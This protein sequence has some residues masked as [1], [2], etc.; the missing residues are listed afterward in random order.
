MFTCPERK[1]NQSPSLTAPLA[2]GLGRAA[3]AGAGAGPGAAG[4]TAPSC[5]PG[6]GLADQGRRPSAPSP[7]SSPAGALWWPGGGPSALAE[8]APLAR[9]LRVSCLGEAFSPLG[10][11]TKHGPLCSRQGSSRP[12]AAPG[13]ARSV[14]C[15]KVSA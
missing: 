8:G 1:K 2:A 5:G 15:G 10:K 12:A 6:R 11:W 13:S 4:P 9:P 14:S 7:R 3:A